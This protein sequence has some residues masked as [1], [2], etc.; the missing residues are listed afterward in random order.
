[1]IV[2]EV[3][4]RAGGDPE[5]KL[6]M[7]LFH[8]QEQGVEQNE[9]EIWEWVRKAAD[10]GSPRAKFIL[11]KNSTPLGKL[12]AV[13]SEIRNQYLKEA[14]DSRV[15]QIFVYEYAK[16]LPEVDSGKFKLLH[17]LA[18]DGYY[19]AALEFDLSKQDVY[20]YLELANAFSERL[21]ERT[22]RPYMYYFISPFL[23]GLISSYPRH[24]QIDTDIIISA[25]ERGSKLG[26]PECLFV[27]AKLY[28]IG[29]IVIRDY[30]KSSEL[31][32][33]CIPRRSKIQELGNFLKYAKFVE[34]CDVLAWHRERAE[35]GDEFSQLLVAI[36][37][38]YRAIRFDD[39]AIRQQFYWCFESAKSGNAYAF[40]LL[41]KLVS[42][43][44]PELMMEISRKTEALLAKY[45]CDDVKIDATMPMSFR[46][47]FAAARL[48]HIS[49]GF[50]LRFSLF[51]EHASSF[52]QYADSVMLRKDWYSD[53]TG[54][55]HHTM[56]SF[57][58]LHN[59]EVLRKDKY[60]EKTLVKQMGQ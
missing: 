23:K 38:L 28:A 19:K 34:N 5:A 35:G 22:F 20:R 11:Y 58:E 59:K 50:M 43:G 9:S 8:F 1:M 25:L 31:L 16:S 55:V 7:A 60:K 27:L 57:L 48:G 17:M 56:M 53:N 47:A 42:R 41:G 4:D 45:P 24:R 29:K 33:R 40:Y 10:D 6:R 54:L 18:K 14:Y 52:Y 36:S 30:D 12:S 44:S 37:L 46:C 32:R 21:D 39:S 15:E 49:S 13:S 51:S 2:S 26:D 3:R